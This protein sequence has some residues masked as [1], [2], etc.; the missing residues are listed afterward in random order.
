M[1]QRPASSAPA[2]PRTATPA[3]P[4]SLPLWQLLSRCAEDLGAATQV[5]LDQ[6][7][8]LD[9]QVAVQLFDGQGQ[10]GAHLQVDGGQVGLAQLFPQAGGHVATVAQEG[11]IR[12]LG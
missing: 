11:L 7:G 8:R 9:V 1:S 12:S 3:H 6:R 4:H 10:A 5:A 2:A